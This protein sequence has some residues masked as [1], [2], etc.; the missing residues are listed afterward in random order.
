MSVNMCVN[1]MLCILFN[2]L[3]LR[4][5][6]VLN[7]VEISLLTTFGWTVA[8]VNVSYTNQCICV[9]SIIFHSLFLCTLMLRFPITPQ[10]GEGSMLYHQGFSDISLFIYL[11][12]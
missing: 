5:L 6:W 10:Q 8:D 7:S 9:P 3:A 1:D 2:R 4:P 12:F 11:V